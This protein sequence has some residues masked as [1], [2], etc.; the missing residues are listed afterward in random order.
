[1][2]NHNTIDSNRTSGELLAPLAQAVS[3]IADPVGPGG[4][5]MFNAS[6]SATSGTPSTAAGRAP[7]MPRTSSPACM[8]VV[9]A[10]CL[11]LGA[12]AAQA[13]PHSCKRVGKDLVLEPSAGPLDLVQAGLEAPAQ[14]P[15]LLPYQTY[16]YGSTLWREPSVHCLLMGQTFDF[17]KGDGKSKAPR[18]TIVYFHGNGSTSHMTDSSPAYLNVVVPAVKLGYNVISVEYRHPVT[19]QYLAQWDGIVPTLDAGYAMQFLRG[20][21]ATYNIDTDHIFSFGHSRGTLALWQMLQPD[22]GGGDTG[23]PSSLPTA[24]FGYQPNTTF[25]CQQFSDLFLVQDQEAIDEVTNCE[26]ANTY[27]QQFGSSVDSV[28]ATSLP[29]HLQTDGTFVLQKGTTDVIKL[30]TYS[31][32]KKLGYN[33]DHY[34]DFSIA[35]L[36]RYEAFSNANM[37]YPEQNIPGKQCFIGWQTFVSAHLGPKVPKVS[38]A[39]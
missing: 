11:L 14:D 23:L 30:L 22:M 19:D 10:A 38:L 1:M 3:V 21:A 18:P 26:T 34:T 27:W 37:D 32:L 4:F 25:Q 20:N 12:T 35:L 8:L 2:L 31:K 28:T 33:T 9:A 13:A 17:F 6:I 7:R 29:V 24:Y 15:K 5:P 16:N 39:P 36:D